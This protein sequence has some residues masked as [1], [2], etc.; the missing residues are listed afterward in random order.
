MDCAEETNLCQEDTTFSLTSEQWLK[1]QPEDDQ[2]LVDSYMKHLTEVKM[3]KRNY[4]VRS[5]QA[6][7]ITF[8]EDV[9]YI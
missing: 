5:D 9:Q 1:I 2:K 6:D 4:N 3:S 7:L 8:L